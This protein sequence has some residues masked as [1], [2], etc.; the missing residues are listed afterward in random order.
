[1]VLAVVINLTPSPR[2]GKRKFADADLATSLE[3]HCHRAG[4]NPAR[5]ESRKFLKTSKGRTANAIGVARSTLC[6]ALRRMGYQK[7]RQRT[8]LCDYCAHF[9]RYETKLSAR[10]VDQFV[11]KLT[12]C[13]FDDGRRCRR[14]HADD[15]AAASPGLGL[16]RLE[17]LAPRGS[18]HCCLPEA[19]VLTSTCL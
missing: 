15:A 13:F 9:A 5:N 12:D 14:V 2:L 4:W 17:C 6:R 10:I 18:Q 8:G 3:P 7:S 16:R 19:R 11:H 1:M